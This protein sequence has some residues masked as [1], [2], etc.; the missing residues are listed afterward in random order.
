[1]FRTCCTCL[2][3]CA[4]TAGFSRPAAAQDPRS[5]V[6]VL[7]GFRAT[8]F[9]DDDLAHD[10]HSLTID[11]R[12]RVVVSGPGYVR[13]LLDT[14]DDGVADQAKEFSA[15]PKTGAQ[16][17][18]FVGRDLVCSGDAGLQIF[19]DD[20]RDDRADG[21]PE[22]FLRILTGGEHH[23][24]SIQRG[25]DGWWY[26]I[27]GNYAGVTD[28]YATLP[29]SPI[30]RPEAG[31]L[32]RIP[33]T[34]AGGEIVAD[35]FR[36]AYDFGTTRQ[37]DIF[38]FDSDGERDVSL[39]W[40]R[41]TRVFHVLPGSHAGWVSRS[42]K[43]PGYF[44]DMPPVVGAF[45]RGSPT[46]VLVYQHDHFPAAF[47]EAVFVLDWTYGRVMALPLSPGG[48]VWKS[49]PV[50]FMS[51]IGSFGFAPTDAA[52]APDGS[53]Y[54]SVGGR[55]TRGG[56]YRVTCDDGK[57]AS[58][59][60]A[61]TDADRLDQVLNAHQPL[62]AWS[63]S[64]W[65]PLARRLGREPFADVALDGERTDR[66]RMRAIEILTELFEG[67]Q[68]KTFTRLAESASE[69]VRARAAWAVGRRHPDKPEVAVLRPFLRDESPLVRRFALEALQSAGEKMN[70]TAVLP[71][72]SECL[73][74]D[75]RFVRQSAASIVAR[76][77]EDRLQPLA[78]LVKS[79][80]QAT[81]ALGLG[82]ASR[83]REVLLNVVE[84]GLSVL[85][86]A[87]GVQH[88]VELRLQAAR[89]M[90]MGLSDV[91]PAANRLPVF[92]GYAPRADLA[93][94][95]QDL[96]PIRARIAEVF[97][98]GDATLDQEISRTISMLAPLNDGLLQKM[99]DQITPET[100]PV[101][102]IHYLLV[103]SR[104]G[105]DR[106]AAQTRATASGLLSLDGK[107]EARKAPRD[108]N[109]VARVGELYQTLVALDVALPQAMVESE[110]FGR[111]AHVA[112]LSQIPRDLLPRAIE[113]FVRVIEQS[114]DAYT[115]TNDV[116]F[117]L[118]ESDLAQHQALVR[119]Q[120]DNPAVRDAVV[121]VLARN[122]TE[123]DR[124]VFVGSLETPDL[125]I[126][127]SSVGALTKLSDTATP[128]ELVALLK[129]ARRLGATPAEYQ[130]RETVVRLLQ[131]RT[132]KEF[133]FVFGESGRRPQR[134]V[135]ARWSEYLSKNYPQLAAAI[136][137]GE[138][139]EVDAIADILAKVD[140]ASGDASR[141]QEIFRKRSCAQCHGGSTA[142]GPSLAGVGSRFSRDDVFTAIVA[143]N[144]DVSPRYRTTQIQTTDGK[145]YQGL[146]IY[147]SVDGL[148]LRTPQN[149]TVRIEQPDTE[150]SRML[151]T[152][153][154]PVGLLRDATAQDLAD[155]YAYL[156]SL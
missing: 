135:F 3:L 134:D 147:R 99:L 87:D 14:D 124:A 78:R 130:F 121:M 45:G 139:D 65:M 12:G 35:G 38:T 104:I 132:K 28:A 34:L 57:L 122:P 97:P 17:M 39:P 47:R 136:D 67:P 2:A 145:V 144:R 82:L 77:P 83:S 92:E 91:G 59:T 16:G 117:A 138:A 101:L 18:F 71:P 149:Q 128:E 86:P 141:G 103:A 100:D 75:D 89:L 98:S 133:G 50:E 102:D 24:H 126:L 119:Q 61:E 72:L 49:Q 10:I 150:L 5:G 129:T 19:R 74:A 110:K 21:D 8:L 79:D 40:Y 120:L 15:K 27:A 137:G 11:S 58:P 153:L 32:M 13:F 69:A 51:G 20:N 29:T 56:V 42:W 31:V 6:R 30:R 44:L 114:G 106:T 113:G 151:S 52:V 94:F 22:V 156:K 80:A 37:G 23:V 123:Q 63:R 7:D 118:G 25:P 142:L 43:R 146:I 131:Q 60:Y 105:V 76:L 111:P 68:N 140:W 115:W 26:V 9:A 85:E 152:S 107:L 81:V 109:W 1:M 66:E 143:P 125:N 155:L 93:A 88:P 95:E 73:G 64:R 70:W 36:N 33:P 48:S 154:M 46:G 62:S 90:Q 84:M 41:P 96:N 53:L 54:I 112:F 108:T 148:L 116:V 127:V 55:G 4:L